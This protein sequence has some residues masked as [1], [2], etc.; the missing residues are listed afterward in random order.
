MA[1]IEDRDYI[2]MNEPTDY[3]KDEKEN[4][5]SPQRRSSV[6]EERQRNTDY[7]RQSQHHSHV[8]ENME[9]ENAQY[10]IAIHPAETERLSLRH[11]YQSDDEGEEQQQYS[12]RPY[13]SLLFANGA[14]DKV[15]VLLRHEF[16]FR[17]CSV[18]KSLALQSARTDGY[19]ALVNIVA[20][21]LQV[22]IETKQHVDAH[23]LMRLHH[24]VQYVACRI[25]ECHRG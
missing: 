7:R 16:Q 12:C 6:A 8:D 15:G 9:E 4:R 19:L 17:L 24:I 14:E 22:F 23:S 10:A 25:E 13:E 1:Y 21:T 5:E 2:E 18:Q 20:G 3:Y 11:L